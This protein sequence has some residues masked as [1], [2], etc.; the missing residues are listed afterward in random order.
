MGVVGN[1]ITIFL[2]WHFIIGYTNSCL[3]ICTYLYTNIFQNIYNCKLNSFFRFLLLNS[4]RKKNAK[5]G[6]R[7]A[8]G[9]YEKRLHSKHDQIPLEI[10][11]NYRFFIHLKWKFKNLLPPNYKTKDKTYFAII[12]NS[13]YKNTSQHL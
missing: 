11:H 2:A 3:Y 5:D 4:R 13:L 9:N 6:K 7:S 1:Y 12:L 10:K 8:Y